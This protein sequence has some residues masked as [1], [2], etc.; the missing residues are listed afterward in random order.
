MD[1]ETQSWDTRDTLAIK[2][3]CTKAKVSKVALEILGPIVGVNAE[4]KRK[5][6][7]TALLS[8]SVSFIQHGKTLD[9]ELKAVGRAHKCNEFVYFIVPGFRI[10]YRDTN[11]VKRSPYQE[12][13]L[14]KFTVVDK[15]VTKPYTPKTVVVTSSSLPTPP[16]TDVQVNSPAPVR[17]W[18]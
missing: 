3:P 2:V 12:S 5:N 13:H 7:G 6:T 10:S 18:W 17:G 4:G 11:G 14:A 9:L 8:T 15:P 1:F 16:A